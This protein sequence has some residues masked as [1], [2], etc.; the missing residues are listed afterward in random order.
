MV[1][2]LLSHQWKSLIRSRNAGRSIAI[3]IFM[4]FIFLYFLVIA[5]SFGVFISAG[6]KHYYPGQ[7]TVKIF[8]GFILYYFLFD[9]ILRFLLQDLPTLTI[10][11]YLIQN[12]RRRTLVE[13][14]NIRSLFSFFNIL[15]L[16]LVIPFAIT[17]IAFHYGAWVTA[18]FIINIIALCIGNHFL[19]LFINRKIIINNWWLVAFL[20]VVL[21]FMAADHYAIFSTRTLSTQFFTGLLQYPWLLVFP[22]IWACISFYNNYSFL[23]SNLYLEEG[24]KSSEI[25]KVYNYSWLQ[26][27]GII[28]ELMTIDFKMI[29]RNKRPR[30]TFMM[31]ALF[32][33]Y[34]F[35][36]YKTQYI[37]KDQFGFVLF[38][39]VFITG[40]FIVQYGNFLLAWQSSHFDEVMTAN[41]GFKVYLKSKFVLMISMSTITLLLALFYGFISWKIIPL[42]I[43]AYLFNIGINT[44]I[45]GLL[46]SRNYKGL[47]LSK[48]SSFN[49]QGAGAV[50]WL[51]MLVVSIV[52]LIIYLP[53][54]LLI[55]SWAGIIAMGV[56]G[57]ISLLLQDWWIDIIAIQI[58]KNKYKILSGF[59][60]K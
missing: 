23:K 18:I 16:V 4:G 60:E 27:F 57:L 12:I 59:R 48:G 39:A 10:Q 36:F 7:D 44:V 47:E 34:G 40:S 8:C 20:M 1:L 32:L 2:T 49:S 28:G 9:L 43:A 30:S 52:G 41:T 19:V 11:P 5:I 45:F 26:N 31:S 6:L 51:S 21:L 35:F 25:N 24:T 55:N 56:F 58:K 15:P 38:G 46:A 22:V 17:N 53:F 37:N 13:F 54:A 42:E 50:H 3:K 14:L 33:L 29:V